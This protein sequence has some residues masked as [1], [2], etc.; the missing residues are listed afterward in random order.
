MD[1]TA[2]RTGQL[3]NY[4]SLA[5]DC[6]VSQPTVKAWLSILETSYIVFR[7]QPYRS[8]L[9]KRLI[10]MPKLHFYDSGLVCWLLGIRTPEQLSAHPLRGAIFESWV[11]SEI[12]KHL[13]NAGDRRGLSF[14]RDRDGAEVDLLIERPDSIT[15]IE[16]KSSRTAS[17][18][19]F[20]GARRVRRHLT[21]ADRPCEVVVAYGGDEA[22]ERTEGRLVPWSGLHEVGL[23]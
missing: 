1:G 11:V 4:S 3:L 18:S 23:W 2:G 9:R 6:G 12:A 14:Y 16:A 20:A 10:K 13:A 19:L 7:I 5:A 15:L 21:D 17:S 8:N 22:Q